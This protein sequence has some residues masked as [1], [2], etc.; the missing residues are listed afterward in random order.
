MKQFF[1]LLST[2]FFCSVSFAQMPP[3]KPAERPSLPYK[4]GERLTYSVSFASFN[5]AAFAETHVLSNGKFKDKD[6]IQIRAKV[7]TTDF[8]GAT[9]FAVE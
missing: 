1:L 3:T 8:V 6:A 7:K 2:L 9:F 5:E 4:L